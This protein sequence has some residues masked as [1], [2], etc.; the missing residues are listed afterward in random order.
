MELLLSKK[1]SEIYG[2]IM[3]AYNGVNPYSDSWKKAKMY[4]V[5][6]YYK[7]KGMKRRYEYMIRRAR[8]MG[9]KMDEEEEEQLET[10]REKRN[11]MNI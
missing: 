7:E 8:L 3:G 1:A 6:K 9:K 5:A 11:R 2:M 4:K 10:E